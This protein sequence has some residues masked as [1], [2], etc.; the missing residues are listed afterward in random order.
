MRVRRLRPSPGV[1]IAAVALVFA[2]AG[3]AYAA[4]KIQT[5]DIA[6]KAVT[7]PKIAK[8]AVKSGKIAKGSVKA[9]DLAAGVIPAVPQ[10]AYGRVNKAGTNVAPVAGAVGI[11]G[12]A[13]GGPGEIC[14]D[15]AFT[16]VSGSATVARKA[17]AQPGSTAELVISPAAGCVAPYTDAA[18][19]TKLSTTGNPTDEDVY[20]Q[21]VR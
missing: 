8:D 5:N 17:T 19:T 15:L 6:K 10:M 3:G 2:L 4:S 7:G 16:P 12:V 11:T 14:Y 20:V 13:N 18:T 21:F 1:L 9:N